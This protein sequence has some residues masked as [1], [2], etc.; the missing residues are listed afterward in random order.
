MNRRLTTTISYDQPMADSDTH[1]RIVAVCLGN[2]CRSP[3]AEAVLTARF[4]ETGLGHNVSVT[5]GGTG[6]WHIGKPADQR[7]RATLQRAGYQSDHRARQFESAWFSAADLIL[8]MDYSNVQDLRGMAPN[9]HSASRVL[10]MRSF[11]P[12][13]MHLPEDDPA[14]AIPDPY[15]GTELDFRTALTMIERSAGG[16]VDQVRLELARRVPRS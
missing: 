6:G 13:L 10:I 12:S 14:L 16:I 9:D 4:A 11:D 2:I 5:S 7:A 8:G 1:Y 15:Y 3:M